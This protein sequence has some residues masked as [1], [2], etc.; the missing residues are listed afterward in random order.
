MKTNAERRSAVGTVAVVSVAVVVILAAGVA[1]YVLVAGTAKA[2]TTTPTTTIS[3]TKTVNVIIPSGVST[4]QSLNFQPASMTLVIGVNNSVRW[5]NDDSA[6]H[7]V[8]STSVP[9]G[10]STF[11]SGNM[12]SGATFTFT[13]T[14]PGTY[15]YQCTYHSLW[16]LGTLLV[17]QTA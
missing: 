16:M 3:G 10:A 15:T 8:M 12:N 14:V 2:A 5:A 1:Y 9:S 6:P 7:D 13:F 4:N 17:K 11:S